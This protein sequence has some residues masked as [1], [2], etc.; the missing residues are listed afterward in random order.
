MLPDLTTLLRVH[1]LGTAG[2]GLVSWPA[3]C[4]ASSYLAPAARGLPSPSL[5]ELVSVTVRDTWQTFLTSTLE[6][7]AHDISWMSLVSLAWVVMES[8]ALCV[9]QQLQMRLTRAA[10]RLSHAVS[11]FDP[12]AE[13][14]E[15]GLGGVGSGDVASDAEAALLHVLRSVN[16]SIL[17]KCERIALGPAERTPDESAVR[18]LCPPCPHVVRA[19]VIC[20][21]VNAL[22]SLLSAA[23]VIHADLNMSALSTN[24][25]SRHD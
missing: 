19:Y 8:A 10:G 17:G 21:R 5:K 24:A 18:R 4:A 11:T 25:S 6:Q 9:C 20:K 1:V 7:T 13:H 15:S 16:L 22:H 23:V 12:S 3:S 14:L 2:E